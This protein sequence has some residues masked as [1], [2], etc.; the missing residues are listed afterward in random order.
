[1][2]P[3]ISKAS[4]LIL[5]FVLACVLVF[6]A[7]DAAQG[8]SDSLLQLFYAEYFSG[9]RGQLNNNSN[10]NSSS[11]SVLEDV[12]ELC[13]QAAL[14]QMKKRLTPKQLLFVKNNTLQEHQ[15]L[16]LHHMKTGGTSMDG[17]V[18][19]GMQ[20]LKA[21]GFV[22]NYTSI[23]EC[24]EAYYSKCISGASV[25]CLQTVRTAAILSYCAPLKD[26]GTPFQW[27]D[28]TQ[29]TNDAPQSLS[30]HAA[31]TVLRHPV[32]RVWSMFRFQTKNCYDCRP[33]KDIYAEIDSGNS[34]LTGMCRLQLLNHQTRNML[35]TAP[36]NDVPD[37]VEQVQEAVH[38]MKTVFTLIG[39]TED[40][41]NTAAMAGKVFPWLA[42]TVDWEDAV[43]QNHSRAL[44][45]EK[46]CPMPHANASPTNNRCGP[47]GK[48]HW[49]LPDVPDDETARIILENN[50]MDVQL[51][52]AAVAQFELQ[53]R[54]L[55]LA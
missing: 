44:A 2:T 32:A 15:F 33:L 48:S 37:S 24:A 31:V 40:M 43:G 53:K 54:A 39:L 34:T 29:E 7:D 41:T 25:R 17:V 51:Y 52:E 16:H 4:T 30:V 28:P 49:K 22:V 45:A 6:V 36:A 1:M 5:T 35:I 10:S 20:R 14:E 46:R 38:N 42:E 21:A 47:D 19:C 26:L 12:T 8:G 11:L 3:A 23:H 9:A 50:Q 13:D 18:D 55:G 27:F